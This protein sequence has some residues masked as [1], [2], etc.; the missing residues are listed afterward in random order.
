MT[1]YTQCALNLPAV[2]T[3][4][5]LA[6]DLNVKSGMLRSANTSTS[7]L[8]NG[9]AAAQAALSNS[10]SSSL[11]T[12][13]IPEFNDLNKSSST[14]ASKTPRKRPAV[15]KKMKS[16]MS[17]TGSADPSDLPDG[18]TLVHSPDLNAG[19][20]FQA[21]I[22]SVHN[23]ILTNHGRVG[24]PAISH[25]AAAQALM[26]KS[27]DLRSV[28]PDKDIKKL[29]VLLRNESLQWL[30]EW[31]KFSGYEALMKK[32]HEVVTIE[33]RS[34]PIFTANAAKLKKNAVQRG[35]T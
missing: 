19:S 26:L 2:V 20:T 31:V 12:L 16:F 32:L 10:A 22:N 24:D 15:M 23:L 25:A 18:F 33:W 4:K 30:S 11:A 34:V 17:A 8:G 29:R 27:K 7:S 1:I 28:D 13:S 21:S 3:R 6:L 9:S 35:T 14:A 5:M